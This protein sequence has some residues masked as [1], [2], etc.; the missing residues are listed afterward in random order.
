M[1]QPRYHHKEKWVCANFG[2]LDQHIKR[3]PSCQAINLKKKI[4]KT[5]RGMPDIDYS[6]AS[7]VDSGPEEF[8]V[9]D[10]ESPQELQESQVIG[11]TKHAKGGPFKKKK[12]HL[13]L[14]HVHP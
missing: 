7:P 11:T 9:D 12:G 10:Q 14:N 6:S 8:K 1:K 2:F 5:R 4:E 3:V 13:H